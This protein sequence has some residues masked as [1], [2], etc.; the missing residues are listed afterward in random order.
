MNE[1]VYE[2]GDILIAT[3]S[4]PELPM[5]KGKELAMISDGFFELEK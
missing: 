3:G 5:I 1:K 2:A 4:K